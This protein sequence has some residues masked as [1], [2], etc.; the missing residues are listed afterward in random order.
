M[1]V[2]LIA[3]IIEQLTMS[4]QTSD[5]IERRGP[6][7]AAVPRLDVSQ[8]EMIGP[9]ASFLV[10][11]YFDDMTDPAG[12]LENEFSYQAWLLKGEV[13]MQDAHA[14]AA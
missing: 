12:P 9:N 8:L 4:V 13:C 3:W 1:I 7:Y 14:A 10:Y 6:R 2:C 11:N 5:E